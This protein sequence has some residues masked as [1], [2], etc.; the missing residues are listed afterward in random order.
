MRDDQP[1]EERAR[2]TDSG[3]QPEGQATEP[4]SSVD[5]QGPPSP[6]MPQAESPQEAAIPDQASDKEG[7]DLPYPFPNPDLKRG[8]HHGSTRPPTISPE[9][10]DLATPN[11]RKEAWRDFLKEDAERKQRRLERAE[12]KRLREQPTGSK[13]APTYGMV[14]QQTCYSQHNKLIGIRL[15]RTI[16]EW[17]C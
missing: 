9:L 13:D 17:C 16:I 3:P 4:T 5:G 6:L 14:S 2:A 8:R 12:S 15:P 11:E 1:E 7:G 10:W